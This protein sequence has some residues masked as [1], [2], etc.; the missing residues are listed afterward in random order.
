MEA[1]LIRMSSVCACPRKIWYAKEVEPD[2]V[3]YRIIQQRFELITMAHMY[4]QK[5]LGLTNS[6]AQVEKT[7]YYKGTPI[8]LVGHIDGIYHDGDPY[9]AEVK[10]TGNIGNYGVREAYRQQVILYYNAIYSAT[11]EKVKDTVVGAHLFICDRES[12]ELQENKVDITEED[13]N[14]AFEH[15]VLINTDKNYA[16]AQEIKLSHSVCQNWCEYNSICIKERIPR[17]KITTMMDEDNR[18]VAGE[19]LQIY[20]E[21]KKLSDR[22]D[23]LKS[24]LKSIG[25]YKYPE[26][27]TV[28]EKEI[29]RIDMTAL[30]REVDTSKYYAKFRTLVVQVKKQ[31]TLAE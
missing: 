13:Y 22:L 30:K 2:P 14:K 5:R 11:G 15:I 12:A 3:L 28:Y 4:F 31:K 23:L 8:L 21:H 7:A 6:E 9:L 19:Y 25:M 1:K 29:N 17:T 18:S 26:G 27:V 16:Y 24:I 10:T 20:E